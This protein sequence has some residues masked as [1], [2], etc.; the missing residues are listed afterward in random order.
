MGEGCPVVTEDCEKL[1]R[2][3]AAQPSDTEPSEVPGV[4]ERYRQDLSGLA[5]DD[6]ALSKLVDA[7]VEAVAAYGQ[8]VSQAQSVQEEIDGRE[9]NIEEIADRGDQV[10]AELNKTCTAG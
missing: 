2:V 4:L 1:H 10:I 9:S 8:A 7:H 5:L 3:L 6:A